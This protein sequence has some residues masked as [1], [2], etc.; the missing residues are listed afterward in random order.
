MNQ[1]ID[2]AVQVFK[3]AW[4]QW[5]T[6]QDVVYDQTA[7]QWTFRGQPLTIYQGVDPA[8][9]QDER[10]DYFA[11]VTIGVTAG[12]RDV[13]VLWPSQA[14]LD[15]PS[16]V[17]TVIEEYGRWLPARIG[18]E[19]TAYQRA[20]QEQVLREQQLPIK[21]IWGAAAPA[22]D[23]GPPDAAGLPPEVARLARK[24][25][26]NRAAKEQRIVSRSVL[27]ESGRIWLRE[28]L[29]D[30]EGEPRLELEGRR[31]HHSCVAF[32]DQATQ[33][34]RSAHD[35]LLDAFDN[36]LQCAHGGAP[37]GATWF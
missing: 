3:P 36:A 27:A 10:A 12:G 13:V 5:Y 8:I 20:L 7:E 30:E 11:H 2:D 37:W 19:V 16:Q 26:G 33:Y 29:P 1:P 23:E 15:F 18:I 4:W 14:R 31:V 24:L 32:F 9:S 6:R 35:D 25:R 17:R 21:A 28:A 22:S 34:P